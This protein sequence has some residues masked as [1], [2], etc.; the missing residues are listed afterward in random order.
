MQRSSFAAKPSWGAIATRSCLKKKVE[1]LPT[2]I[3]VSS[4]P[5]IMN[6]KD[7]IKDHLLG[8]WLV[9][10]DYMSMKVTKLFPPKPTSGQKRK[11]C[12]AAEVGTSGCG[13]GRGRGCGWGRCHGRG[14]RRQGRGN[15][16][17]RW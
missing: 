8:D 13:S 9:A 5:I 2:S 10:M 17:G 14:G 16:L 1:R 4:L 3:N 7:D 6:A 12:L 15:G 11:E